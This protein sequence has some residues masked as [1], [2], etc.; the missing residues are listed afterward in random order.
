MTSDDLLNVR[1][2]IETAM[3]AQMMVDLIIGICAVVVAYL[4]GCGHE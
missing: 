2:A 4:I 1:L 3:H